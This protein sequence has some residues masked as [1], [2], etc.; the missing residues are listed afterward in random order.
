[1]RILRELLFYVT[2]AMTIAIAPATGGAQTPG[3]APHAPPKYAPDVP[4]KTVQPVLF[5]PRGRRLTDA[6]LQQNAQMNACPDLQ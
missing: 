4:A 6:S 1:M 2:A 3:G 5:V